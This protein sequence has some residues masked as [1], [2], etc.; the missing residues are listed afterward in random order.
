MAK[1]KGKNKSRGGLWS[2]LGGLMAAMPLIL[3]A[4]VA[5]LTSL[6]NNAELRDQRKLLKRY[7]LDDLVPAKRS[8]GK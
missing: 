5:A 4:L 3:P 6:L 8:K 2:F 7:G 1:K